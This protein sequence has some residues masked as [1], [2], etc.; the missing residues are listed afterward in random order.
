M[1]GKSYLDTAKLIAKCEF[2]ISSDS[3][4]THLAQAIGTETICIY[5]AFSSTSRVGN[6]TNIH[7]FDSNPECRC[8]M[9]QSGKCKKGFSEPVCLRFNIESIIDIIKHKP[10]IFDS[11]PTVHAPEIELY[12]LTNE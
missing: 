4:I 3:L 5:G 12:G 10:T 2:I 7:I 11:I 9:H 1:A 8:F 6:Y